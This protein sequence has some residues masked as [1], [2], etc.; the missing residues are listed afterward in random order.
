MCGRTSVGKSF[1]CSAFRLVRPCVRPVDA[2]HIA[3]GH[4]AFRGD[5]SRPKARAR[6]AMAHMD[7][8]ALGFDRTVHYTATALPKLIDRRCRLG[9]HYWFSVTLTCDHH[10]PDRPGYLVGKSDCGNLWRTPREK[11]N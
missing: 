8:P 9:D 2:A 6:G 4:N 3:A 11:L 10:R 5:G 7:F 1:L